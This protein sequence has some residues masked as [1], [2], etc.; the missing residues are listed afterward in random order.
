V[1]GFI[2]S[3]SEAQPT[4]KIVAFVLLAPWHALSIK[5]K[6]KTRLNSLF[7]NIELPPLLTCLSRAKQKGITG[8][9]TFSQLFYHN[10]CQQN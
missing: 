6:M 9:K 5:I 8:L 10:S 4:R 7:L 1:S 2:V 3:G